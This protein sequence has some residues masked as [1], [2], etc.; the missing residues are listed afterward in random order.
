MLRQQVL[1]A[2]AAAASITDITPAGAVGSA[3]VGARTIDPWC[4]VLGVHL[5]GPLSPRAIELF[6]TCKELDAIIL[7]P[8]CLDP[9]T[10]GELK[11]SA[12][13]AGLDPYE[14]KIE[15]LV[16][17][18][19]RVDDG[20]TSSDDVENTAEPGS[21]RVDVSVLRDMAMRTNKGGAR[22]EGATTCKNAVISGLRRP[23]PASD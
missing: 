7:V 11:A 18:L 19:R 23:R 4:V 17:M 5:C 21:A 3:D 16:E 14:A 13:A 15:Q 8:C 20:D 22:S 10:D 6:A 2:L 12:R 9:W 1:V